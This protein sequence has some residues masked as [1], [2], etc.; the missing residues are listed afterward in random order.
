MLLR[1][2]IVERDPA[3][4]RHLRMHLEMLATVQVIG[5]AS[6]PRDLGDMGSGRPDTVFVGIPEG[7]GAPE[8][9]T[10]LARMRRQLPAVP[11][12]A[13]G[14]GNSADLVIQALRAGAVEFVRQPCSKEDLAA[15]IDK[16]GRLRSV[17]Q[18]PHAEPGRVTAVFSLKG[19]LGQTTLA[20]NLAVCLAAQ[21]KR[22]VVLADFDIRQGG[23]ATALGLTSIYSTLDAFAQTERLDEAFLRGLLVPHPSGVLVLPA[24]GDIPQGHFDPDQ[25]RSGLEIVRGYFKHVILDLPHDVEPGTVAALEFAEEILYVVGLNVPALRAGAAG[26]AALRQLGIASWKFKVVVA[27]ANAR[28]EVNLKAAREALG[29]PIF[30][31]IPNDYPTVAGSLNE[32]Q[33]LV[34]TAPRSEVARSLHHL[35]EQLVRGGRPA[36]GAKHDSRWIP[37]VVRRILTRTA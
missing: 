3:V 12:I 31:C 15:A 21:A 6:D 23:V 14:A 27:R 26:V 7:P 30:W 33:P 16:V 5:E 13:T 32:G 19:G 8:V 35:S 4:R 24:P 34:L 29:L 18:T 28:D 1:V 9:L 17:A 36:P 25:V 20:T 2:W 11:V 10:A 37:S 22:S